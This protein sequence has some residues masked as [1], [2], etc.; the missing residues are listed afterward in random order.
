[1]L[2]S[3]PELAAFIAARFAPVWQKVRAAPQ[4]SVD[5]GGGR[6]VR[7]TLHGNVATWILDQDGFV[8]DVIGGVY[9]PAAYRER[10]EEALRLH[11]LVRPRHPRLLEQA[12]VRFADYHARQRD[13]LA[14]SGAPLFLRSQGV[15]KAGVERWALVAMGDGRDDHDAAGAG[16]RHGPA[17][18]AL[19]A[20]RPSGAPVPAAPAS[21]LAKRLIER[22][23]RVASGVDALP[24]EADVR[25]NETARRGTIHAILAETGLVRFDPALTSRV[26]REALHCD[27]DDPYLGLG[28][29]LFAGYPFAR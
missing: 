15:T 29:L 16:N 20:A 2:F 4:V 19:L 14:R 25:F 21:D 28:T 13:A 1:V 9:A 18:R 6:V 7:R 27:L 11:G 10:L 8:L 24:L 26:Y 17:L 12:A 5:F 22:A 3:Q 23:P